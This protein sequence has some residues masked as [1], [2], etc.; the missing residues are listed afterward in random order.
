VA[1]VRRFLQ[2]GSLG[3][4]DDT[5]HH[6]AARVITPALQ[7]VGAGLGLAAPLAF[8]VNIRVAPDPAECF[9]C[10]NCNVGC[11]WDR[12][13]SMLDHT[14]PRAQSR[15]PGKLTILA[16]CEAERFRTRTGRRYRAAELVAHGSDGRPL[17]IRADR[18][19]VAAGAIASS[20]LLLRSGIGYRRP[21]GRHLAFNML[22]PVF[23]EFDA[24]Q[25]SYAGIQMGHYV[26][27]QGNEFIIETW[28]SPPV[29]LATAMAGWFGDHYRNMQRAGHLVAYG[30]VV[31][32]SA[33]GSVGLSPLTGDSTFRFHPPSADMTRLGHG[34]EALAGVLF[35]AGARRVLLNTW[36][37][38]TLIAP[39]DPA[40]IRALARNPEF[41][42]LASSHPQGG[43]AINT[44][45]ARGVVD[46]HFRVHGY[47]NLYV[48][49][50]SVFPG[51]VQVNPQMTV[52]SLARYA[53]SQIA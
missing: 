28:F 5:R 27:H 49:D 30:M 31:G 32:T 17:V 37:D 15:F 50:A 23:A 2:V 22:T 44:S 41:I 39:L 42:T 52:M 43:N 47:E 40:R 35:E 19:I 6:P 51:S 4:L 7:R 25:D 48:T 46:P 33:T 12:K 29:G 16:E 8:E 13:L 18:F 24:P 21:V 38:G 34:L 26:T 11:P 1:W 53:A 20:A 36:D 14:L 45:S 3:L 10:G 9:G